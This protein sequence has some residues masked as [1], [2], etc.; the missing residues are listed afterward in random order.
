MNEVKERE[1]TDTDDVDSG[2][3]AKSKVNGFRGIH[4]RRRR[5]R[6]RPE[7][8]TRRFEKGVCDLQ[9]NLKMNK[10]DEKE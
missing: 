6:T 4:R 1:D 5:L 2:I 7:L 8:G 3:I 10:K 9:A